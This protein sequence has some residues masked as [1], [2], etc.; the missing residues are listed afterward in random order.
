MKWCRISRATKL[1]SRIFKILK[2]PNK[3]INF[4]HLFFFFKNFPLR[5]KIF[6]KLYNMLEGNSWWIRIQNLKSISSKNGWDIGNIK[7][8]KNR[9]FSRHFGTWPRFFEFCF[10]KDFDASKSVFWSFFAFFAK[11]W[12]K[13]MYRT[14][15]SRHFLLDLFLPGDLRWPWLL[16]WSKNTVNDTYKCQRHYPCR[17][18]GFF[19]L[20]IAILLAD[21]NKPEMSNILTLTWPVTSLVTTRAIKFV[22]PGQFSRAFKCRLNF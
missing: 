2:Y 18:V 19:V 20:N 22:F 11:I 7:H 14:S 17:L 6:K 21:V 13:N 16:L 4:Q 1:L 15:K 12:P 10:L 9:H 5:N 3:N 8:V